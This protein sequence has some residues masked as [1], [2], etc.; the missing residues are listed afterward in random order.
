MAFLRHSVRLSVLLA[1]S[2]LVSCIDC[3]EEIWL[4]S[5]G[6]GR[7][8]L[9]YTLPAAAARFQGGENGVRRMIEQFLKSTPT[10]HSSNCEVSTVAD[11]LTI[12]VR[13][14]FDSVLDFKEIS[15]SDSLTDLPS[16]AG[17]LAG[18]VTLKRSGRTF[19]IARTISA[20]S[21]LP[22]AIFLPRSQFKDRN[23]AYVVHLPVLPEESNATRTEDGGR[24][25]IWEIPL[26]QAVKA[27]FTTRFKAKAP[28]PAWMLASAAGAAGC[29]GLLTFF[30]T[31][32]LRKR[33][34]PERGIH[35][36]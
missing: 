11:R 31:R 21:A 5:D 14:A 24:T 27:P 28:I 30:G 7:A 34:Q 9:S 33:R 2:L 25:L 22:G 13:G 20:G 32:K 17:N 36:S 18:E 19:D 23:L 6:S 12:R 16:S 3:R 10:I 15:Q 26:G 35:P 29:V 4:N 1:V 8:D